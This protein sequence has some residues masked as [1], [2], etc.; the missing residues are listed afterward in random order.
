MVEALQDRTCKGG[1]IE[2]DLPKT[3]LLTAEARESPAGGLQE[4]TCRKDEARAVDVEAE[5]SPSNQVAAPPQMNANTDRL[6]SRSGSVV[7]L[8]VL[9]S[10][11]RVERTAIE[12]L[13][14]R[15]TGRQCPEWSSP[16]DIDDA[17]RIVDALPNPAAAQRKDSQNLHTRA[18]SVVSL[19]ILSTRYGEN[20]STVEEVFRRVT[21]HRCPE[22]SQP[23]TLDDAR[24]M[25]DALANGAQEFANLSGEIPEAV[26]PVAELRQFSSEQLGGIFA[27]RKQGRPQESPSMETPPTIT[28]SGSPKDSFLIQAG[29]P[30]K[31]TRRESVASESESV[32]LNYSALRSLLSKQGT[33]T[34][35]E[36]DEEMINGT[37]HSP[38]EKA[39]CNIG[40]VDEGEMHEI[41]TAWLVQRQESQ[42]LAAILTDSGLSALGNLI[43]RRI[44]TGELPS[45][46]FALTELASAAG[47]VPDSPGGVASAAVV[48][49]ILRCLAAIPNDVLPWS[50]LGRAVP[51]SWLFEHWE[52]VERW[53]LEQHSSEPMVTPSMGRCI[54]VA[55]AAKKQ[56]ELKTAHHILCEWLRHADSLDLRRERADLAEEYLHNI[57]AKKHFFGR[58]SRL[59][60][61]DIGRGSFA[62]VL[63]VLDDNT[64]ERHALKHTLLLDTISSDQRA[65]NRLFDREARL[66]EELL[67]VEGIPRLLARPSNEAL[68]CEWIDGLTLA[69]IFGQSQSKTAWYSEDVLRLGFRL[70]SILAAIDERLRGFV[71]ND[72]APRNLML[73]GGRPEATVLIDLGLAAHDD[74]SV[75]TLVPYFGLCCENKPLVVSLRALQKEIPL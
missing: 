50:V 1:I 13:F 72:I 39:A 30:V 8:H 22:W 69:E 42:R 34:N 60:D 27:K 14:K 52:E 63:P 75:L 70:S 3:E 7:S 26:T 11:Y 62:L 38:S 19:H 73:P 25:V 56:G 33:E 54:A 37:V 23:L 20:R 5:Q 2:C 71:H 64:G 4:G 17:R 31:D 65:S 44:P 36:D 35:D 49:K 16:L 61:L 15:L 59:H 32:G 58:W 9:S 24:C 28:N 29:F 74:Y 55:R 48:D 66:L 68:V 12:E 46:E 67:G 45:P 18:G 57:L 10:T 6:I 43:N 40:E 47:L 53:V 41:W 21:G 51:S